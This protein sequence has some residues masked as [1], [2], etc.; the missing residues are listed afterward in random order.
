MWSPGWRPLLNRPASGCSR[1]WQA[2]GWRRHAQ[3]SL[4]PQPLR[5]LGQLA[6]KKSS[7]ATSIP[8]PHYKHTSPH[9]MGTK[10]QLDLQRAGKG[11]TEVGARMRKAEGKEGADEQKEVPEG[12]RPRVLV[13]PGRSLRMRGTRPGTLPVRGGSGLGPGTSVH[14][15]TLTS[16]RLEVQHTADDVLRTL[17][18]QKGREP[19]PA[20]PWRQGVAQGLLSQPGG[21]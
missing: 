8:L 16:H 4:S 19:L 13:R 18:W 3:R 14:P 9:K 5:A 2:P 7:L 21:H 6:L 11:A 15:S 20:D 17:G 12:H 10:P 1:L